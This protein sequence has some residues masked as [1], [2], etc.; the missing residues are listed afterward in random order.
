MLS[1]AVLCLGSILNAYR[2]LGKCPFLQWE[3]EA[4]SIEQG[5]LHYSERALL[6]E[7]STCTRHLECKA[8]QLLCTVQRL[9]CV[10]I[11]ELQAAGLFLALNSTSTRTEPSA[12]NNKLLN[13]VG[14]A[15]MVRLVEATF[16]IQYCMA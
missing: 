14:P 9:L 13:D 15:A 10:H 7:E 1:T 2:D 6:L 12:N 5:R 4:G 11:Y 3:N 8:L 16:E